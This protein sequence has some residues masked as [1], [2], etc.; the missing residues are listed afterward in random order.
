M[1]VARHHDELSLV[2]R[3]KTAAAASPD[4]P[5]T[6][7]EARLLRRIHRG[8]DVRRALNTIGRQFTLP[9]LQRRGLVT[10]E[11]KG[12]ATTSDVSLSLEQP[13]SAATS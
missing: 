2:P 4:Q 1:S 3:T 11:G 8:E 7:A 13:R 9:A 10:D 6:V 12:P 5:L